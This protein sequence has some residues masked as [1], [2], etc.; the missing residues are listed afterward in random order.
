M[1]HV[2]RL[3][4]LAKQLEFVLL[5]TLALRGLLRRRLLLLLLLLS[6]LLLRI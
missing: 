3:G 2:R 1:V 6:I 5:A 4:I